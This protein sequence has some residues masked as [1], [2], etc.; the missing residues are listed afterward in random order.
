M[1]LQDAPG[2]EF[3]TFTDIITDNR[4][5]IYLAERDNGVY[6]FSYQN[7]TLSDATLLVLKNQS[8][9]SVAIT[10]IDR[11]YYLDIQMKS[12]VA[13]FYD[14]TTMIKQIISFPTEIVPKRIHVNQNN[15]VV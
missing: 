7:K 11:Y 2:I 8:V 14:F 10:E 6:K 9:N 4:G 13:R 15:L 5:F 1:T 3:Q 12:V